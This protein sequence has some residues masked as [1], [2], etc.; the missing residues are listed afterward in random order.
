RIN[1]RAVT[2]AVAGG[3]HDDVPG[4]AEV[5]A[6][7][8]ELLLRCVAGRVLALRRVG[9]LRARSEHVTMRIHAAGRH[10]ELRLRRSRVPVQPAGGFLEF[11]IALSL[12]D[13]G[14]D[15]SE[16]PSTPLLDPPT[17]RISVLSAAI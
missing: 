5:V 4:E 7:R 6:Q 9:E 12:L 13:V 10:L 14:E 11:H 2:G 17:V 8:V 15:P 1:Q 3:L 16:L